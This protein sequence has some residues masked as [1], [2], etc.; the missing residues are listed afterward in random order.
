MANT[1]LPSMSEEKDIVQI[2]AKVKGIVARNQIRVVEFMEGFDKH[3]ELCIPESDFRRGLD[4]ANVKLSINEV[5]Q[6]CSA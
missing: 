6:L 3:R 2:V 1:Q 5:D 4:S